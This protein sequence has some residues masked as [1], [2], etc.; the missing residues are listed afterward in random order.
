VYDGPPPQHHAR[1][2]PN[3]LDALRAGNCDVALSGNACGNQDDKQFICPLKFWGFSRLIERSAP[4]EKPAPVK[5]TCTPSKDPYGKVSS[6]LY[7]ASS[8]AFKYVTGDAEVREQADLVE[9]L[10]ALCKPIPAISDWNQWRTEVKKQP[11]LLVLVV[12][13]EQQLGIRMLEI[14]N[15]AMLNDSEILRDI[16]GE[17]ERPLLVLLLGC[18]V[19]N[20]H[21]DFQPFPELFFHAGAKIVLAPISLIRGRDAVLIAKRLSALLAQHLSSSKPTTFGDL[22]P[23]LRRELLSQGYPGILGL[24]GF[25]DGDWI[26]GGPDVAH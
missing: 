26:L 25:G 11:N 18:S 8:R 16:T 14:G 23:L 7:A 3:S 20:V 22:L 24:V 9:A 5:L 10:S 4:P 1:V 2:C 12:H 19:A 21:E 6:L 13:A 15:G 17:V